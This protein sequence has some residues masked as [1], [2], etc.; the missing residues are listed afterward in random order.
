MLEQRHLLTTKASESS[1][2]DAQVKT[3]NSQ[4]AT[5]QNPHLLARHIVHATDFFFFAFLANFVNQRS[6]FWSTL[7]CLQKQHDFFYFWKTWSQTEKLKVFFPAQAQ[8]DVFYVSLFYFCAISIFSF[9]YMYIQDQDRRAWMNCAER[10]NHEGIDTFCA[11][12][13]RFFCSCGNYLIA[14]GESTT[15]R[16]IGSVPWKSHQEDV[17]RLRSKIQLY[18]QQNRHHNPGGTQRP[19]HEQREF[20]RPIANDSVKPK[21]T[22]AKAIHFKWKCSTFFEQ[23]WA[24]SFIFM[25]FV[26]WNY[27]PSVFEHARWSGMENTLQD[28]LPW[29]QFPLS[30]ACRACHQ[31]RIVLK[32]LYAVARSVLTA[33]TCVPFP[34]V[35][36]GKHAIL[37]N[38]PRKKVNFVSRTAFFCGHNCSSKVPKHNLEN[39]IYSMSFEWYLD[40]YLIPI[41]LRKSKCLDGKW[42]PVATSSNWLYDFSRGHWK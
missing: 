7:I 41:E 31:W 4:S 36:P 12:S 11:K 28:T 33:R 13:Q 42:W 8:Q 15:M 32:K 30:L 5:E 27:K 34:S 37:H 24:W 16:S 1:V 6:T 35:Q 14:S 17:L 25:V 26:L 3:R 38:C 10:R 19:G 2:R 29:L 21:A 39:P 23:K 40:D 20:L 22:A 18:N 9:T